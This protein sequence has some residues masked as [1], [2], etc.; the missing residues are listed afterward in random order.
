MARATANHN[1]MIDLFDRRCSI[2]LQPFLGQGNLLVDQRS[3]KKL[4]RIRS[5]Y[6]LWRSSRHSD[7][8]RLRQNYTDIDRSDY[9]EFLRHC[10][11]CV[12]HGF[13]TCATVA[14][15]SLGLK[16]LPKRFPD[17]F[18]NSFRVSIPDAPQAPNGRRL[19]QAQTNIF[20][21]D[22]FPWASG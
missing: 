12:A 16:S 2:K 6:P 7:E 3:A 14:R 19:C 17:Y 4:S 8:V 22:Y 18:D 13:N 10:I 21:D 15:V 1:R 5:Q 11:T 9:A 20:L